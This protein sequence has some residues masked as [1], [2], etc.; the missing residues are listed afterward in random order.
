M[1]VDVPLLEQCRLDPEA[2]RPAPDIAQRGR[3]TFLHHVAQLA[4]VFQVAL[5]RQQHTLDRQQF[6][7]HLGPGKARDDPDHVLV[8]GLTV[9]EHAHAGEFLQVLPG[10]RHLLGFLGN[11]LHHCLASQLGD[12]PL[13]RPDAS[14]AGVVADEVVQRIVMDRPLLQLQPVGLALLG[15]QVSLGDLDLLVLGVAG[16]ADDLHA[17]QQR[18][19]HP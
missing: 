13:Q 1:H 8:L 7:A 9:A 11:D 4:G 19:R 15:H 2:G 12:L 17:V 5:T 16:D 6:A 10:E 18:L 14:L 3:H